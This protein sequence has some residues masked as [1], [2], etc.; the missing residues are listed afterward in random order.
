MLSV[1]G[2]LAGYL[3]LVHTIAVTTLTALT[4]STQ[5]DAPLGFENGNITD[6]QF[7]ASSSLNS[8]YTAN[9][10]RLNVGDGWVAQQSNGTEYLQVDLLTQHSVT[11]YSVQ[12][13][14]NGWFPG[15]MV[16]FYSQDS[17]VWGRYVT[18][19]GTQTLAGPP[20]YRTV[21][22]FDLN[23]A[24]QARYLAFV[25]QRRTYSS[26]AGLRLELYG[27]AAEQQIPVRH[28][29]VSQDIQGSHE[30]LPSLSPYVINTA[31][32][33]RPAAH[34][35]IQPG[36]KVIFNSSHAGFIVLGTMEARGLS[37]LPVVFTA[38]T[39]F[40]NRTNM[41]A[42]IEVVSQG[43][44]SLEFSHIYGAGVGIQ[45]TLG[46]MTI[47]H[48]NI[49]HNDR[50]LDLHVGDT[51]QDRIHISGTIISDNT[52]EGIYASNWP[53]GSS[54]IG[55]EDSDILRNGKSGMAFGKEVVLFA[56]NCRFSDNK[57]HG[58]Y[59]NYYYGGMG[60]SI[61]KCMFE[62]NRYTG[63][64][65]SNARYAR[66]LNITFDETEFKENQQEGLKLYIQNAASDVYIS[67]TNSHF[68]N[69][70][71]HGVQIQGEF[72]ST[73]PEILLRNNTMEG[74]QTTS[75]QLMYIETRSSK[76][77]NILMTENS[78]LTRK[79]I[80]IQ[81]RNDV[82]FNISNN[83][84]TGIKR[85]TG[86]LVE[87]DNTVIF[88]NIF[89]NCSTTSV[90]HTK[91]VRVQIHS[92]VF[93]NPQTLYDVFVDVD[94]STNHRL[95]A[96]HN[97]WGSSDKFFVRSR[98]C[99]FFCD[100]TK[101]MAEVDPYFVS[102]M[103][104][105]MSS[106]LDSDMFTLDDQSMIGGTLDSPIILQ[107][108]QVLY[109]NRSLY[110]PEGIE[111][112]ISK[113]NTLVFPNKQGIFVRGLLT[114][115]GEADAKVELRSDGS[116]SSQRWGGIIFNATG[117]SLRHTTL[118]HAETGMSVSVNVSGE[119]RSSDTIITQCTTAIAGQ[120]WSN[121]SL[122]LERVQINESNKFIV[123]DRLSSHAVSLSIN[124]SEI[125]SS[126][127]IRLQ[128]NANDGRFNVRI[129][130][131]KLYSSSKGFVMRSCK[132]NI[133][134]SA[135]DSVI[136]SGYNSDSFDIDGGVMNITFRRVSVIGNRAASSFRTCIR[137]RP[138]VAPG[139]ID[140]QDSLF[141]IRSA[142]ILDFGGTY[143]QYTTPHDVLLINNTFRTQKQYDGVN[144]YVWSN[145]LPWSLGIHGNTFENCG[146][147]MEGSIF[148]T[149]I[150]GNTFVNGKSPLDINLQTPND[151]S[152]RISTNLFQGGL[153]TLKSERDR[154]RFYVVE[155]TFNSS[156]I[157]LKSPNVTLNEN[158]FHADQ[159]FNIKFEGDGYA[160]REINSTYNYWGT[161]DAKDIAR[162][163]FD[164]SYDTSLPTIKL[165]PFYGFPNLTN[166][167]SPVH[168]FISADGTIGGSIGGTV[169]LA[170]E[171]SPYTVA[172]N[173]MVGKLETLIVEAGVTLQFQKGFGIFVE[174]ALIVHGNKSHPVKAKPV[175]PGEKWSGVR[176]LGNLYRPFP[177]DD[178]SVR[179][180]GGMNENEGRLEVKIN[181]TWGTVC[182]DGFDRADAKVVCRMLG[183]DYT[184]SPDV[185]S[186]SNDGLGPIHLGNLR[187]T[188]TE[189]TLLE[190]ES[191]RFNC[192]HREDVALRCSEK[193]LPTLQ[194]IRN[195]VQIRHFHMN[196]TDI[197]LEINGNIT[198]MENVISSYSSGHGV[199]FNVGMKGMPPVLIN[200]LEAVH[201][202]LSGIIVAF[203]TGDYISSSQI[204]I[205][206]C[207]I[208]SNGE[209]G[210]YI[211]Q[212]VDISLT[213]CRFSRNTKEDIHVESDAFIN[214]L[215]S[216]FSGGT[217]GVF[218][219]NLRR[220]ANNVFKLSFRDSQFHDYVFPSRYHSWGSGRS[221]FD[222]PSSN[223]KDLDI[224]FINNT[225]NRITG[226][227]F[228]IYFYY[229]SSVHTSIRNNTFQNITGGI[230]QLRPRN[231]IPFQLSFVNNTVK[232]TTSL[233]SS[234]SLLEIRD[235]RNAEG[236]VN[237][238]NNL[239]SANKAAQIILLGD[240][241]KL[242]GNITKNIFKDNICSETVNVASYQFKLRNNVFSNPSA[243]CELDAPTFE[244]WYA[245]DAR[246]NFW[247]KQEMDYVGESICGFDIDMEKGFVHYLPYYLSEEFSEV[248]RND[249]LIFSGGEITSQVHLQTSA[250]PYRIRTSIF[251]RSEGIL[252]IDSGVELQ[253]HP[254]RGIY[255]DGVLVAGEGGTAERVILTRAANESWFGVVL[256]Y[257][258]DGVSETVR[259]ANG[260]TANEGR[261]EVFVKGSWS[262]VC[263]ID[264][265]EA[266]LVCRAL[267]YGSEEF[268]NYQHGGGS[269]PVLQDLNCDVMASSLSECQPSYSTSRYCNHN[270]DV[271]V[272]CHQFVAHTGTHTFSYL[273]SVSILDSKSGLV[274]QTPTVRL[275]NCHVNN[276]EKVG[277]T[278]QTDTIDIDLN[279]T[280]V[281]HGRST[282]ILTKV[283]KRFRLRNGTTQHNQGSGII[284][285]GEISR[286][287][288]DNMNI[289]NNTLRGLE[290][291]F[292]GYNNDKM[293]LIKHNNFLDHVWEGSA[294][295]LDKYLQPNSMVSL[296]QNTFS[297]NV[298]SMDVRLSSYYYNYN[299][300]RCLIRGNIFKSTGPVSVYSEYYTSV[301]IEDNTFKNSFGGDKCFFTV[302]IHNTRDSGKTQNISLST[303]S[304]QN[305]TGRCVVFVKSTQY[306][307][308][309]TL[310]YNR[311]F[312]SPASEATVIL[313]SKN[314]SLHYNTLDNPGADY[315]LKILLTGEE[316]IN[317]EQNW[318]GSA[319]AAIA[320][321]R[322]L[323]KRLDQRLLRVDFLPILTDQNFDCSEVKNCSD[324]GECV[325][326]NGCRCD[327]GWA[328][329]D[330]S[331][332]DCSGVGNCNGNGFCIGPNQCD[333]TLGWEGLSCVLATCH[334]VNDC[335]GD[336]RGYCVLPEKCTCF[337]QYSGADC[338][339][340]AQLRWGDNCLPCPQCN[341]GSCNLTN[342]DCACVAENW[343]GEL[344]DTC[345]ET[346]YG[347][348]C[349][350]YTN[351]LNI[352]PSSGRDTGGTDVH[353]WGHN[354]PE[355]ENNIFF[356]RFDSTV[357]SGTR[358]SKEHITCKNP[359]HQAGIVIVEISPDGLQ[360][361]RNQTAFTY[362]EVC[363][364]GACG[365]T[366]T[367]PHGHCL[368]GGC[369]C[370]LPW[371]GEACN[372][373]LKAPVISTVQ[374]KQFAAEGNEYQ[375]QLTLIEGSAP[376]DWYLFGA[377]SGMTIDQ[378]T[379]LIFWERTVARVQPYIINARASNRV[380][381]S[382]VQWSLTVQL[383]YNITIEEVAPSGVL[384]VPKNIQISGMVTY[385]SGTAQSL[386][387]FVDVKVRNKGRI[388]TISIVTS[389]RNRERFEAVYFPKAGDSGQFEVD[390]RHPSDSGFTPQK[391]WS[392]LG[393]TCVPGYVN[394]Q[395]YLD[396]DVVEMRGVTVLKNDGINGINGIT[397]R[398]EGTGGPLTSVVVRAGNRLSSVGSQPLIIFL[399]KDSEV[400]I[401]LI[402]TASRPLRGVIAVVFSTPD[403]TTARV[404][405][406][407]QLNVRKPVLVVSPTSLSD[408]VPRGTQKTFQVNIKNEGE[409]TAKSLRVTMP[410]EPRLT[411]SA[412]ST[413]TRIASVDGLD[414]QPNETAILVLTVTTGA[415]DGLGQISG[416]VA[417][418]SDLSSASISY[419]FYVT[420]QEKLNITVRVEDEYTYFASDKPLVSGAVVTLRNP[421]RGY[422]EQRITTNQTEFVVFGDVHEDKYTLTATA[423]GHGSYSR[424]VIAKPSD[425]S[426]T[427]F[428]QRVAVKYTWTVTRTTFE[429]KYTIT[430][431]STFETQVPMPVVTVEPANINL[432][433]YEEGKRDVINFNITNHGLIRADNARFALPSH[434]TLI[435]TQTIDP[436]GG[437]EANTSVIVPVLVKLKPRVKR[438]LGTS[439]CGLKML[440]DYYC[441]GTKTGGQ[442]ITLTR[443]Y[444]GRPPLPC[445]GGVGGGRGGGGGGY[446]GI[447]GTGGGGSSPSSSVVV[448]NPVTPLTCNCA[449]TLIKTCALGFH[450][451]AGCAVAVTGFS[452]A[453]GFWGF[454][455]AVFDFAT[456]CVLPVACPQCALGLTLWQ[457]VVCI[458]EMNR[459]CKSKRR[460]RATNGEIIQG[461]VN[462]N[463]A[464]RN[465]MIML[466][467]LFGGQEMFGVYDNS[468]TSSFNLALADDSAG[469]SFLS[470]SEV[471][472]IVSPMNSTQSETVEKFL[473]RWNK[474]MTAWEGGTLASLGPKDDVIA[475]N[476]IMSRFE[477]FKT[478]TDN[479]K[480]RGFDSI[481]DDF[482]NAVNA[483][484]ESEKKSS[485]D[486]GVCAKVRVRIVQDLVLTRDAF[487]ARLEI[488]NGEQSALD[489]I[490]VTVNI[491]ATYGDETSTN[492]KFSVGTPTLVGLTGVDG[493]GRLE[494][495]VSGTAEW[496]IIPYSTAAVKED[497]LYDV[498]G[499]LSYTV[500]GSNFSIPLLPDTITVKP[501][502]S[503]TVNYF[504]EKYVQGD[505]PM[506][507][508][509][510]EPVVPFTLAVM[511]SN[512]AYGV[513]RQLKITSAQPEIIE[514]E[515]GLLVAFKIIGAQLDTHPVSPS[516]SIDF[517]DIESFE[518]KTARWLL[519]STL[520]GK[521]Y[522]YTATFENINPLGDPQLSIMEDLGYH[523]LVHLV[524]LESP[525]D[526]RDDF[527]VN[528]IIDEDE[529][530]DA[531]FDSSNGF[532]SIPVSSSNVM[533]FTL[534]RTE[535]VGTRSYAYVDL[536]AMM[537][538]SSFS[539]YTYTR[540]VN[541]LTRDSATDT[542]LQ[543]TRDDGKK[544][545]VGPNAWQTSYYHDKFYLH[546]FD[547]HKNMTET[548]NISYSLVFGPKNMYKPTFTKS[549][550]EI[551]VAFD[552]LPGPIF[553][554][555]ATD[556][557]PNTQ[558]RYS[559]DGSSVF[560]I[561]E[562]TGEVRS[563]EPLTNTLYEL[564]VTVTDDGIPSL[565]SSVKVVVKVGD[566]SSSSLTSTDKSSVTGVSTQRSTSQVSGET[567][568]VTV[569]V[570]VSST[571]VTATSTTTDSVINSTSAVDATSVTTASL[572]TSNE[573]STGTDLNG[574]IVSSSTSVFA[575]PGT[576]VSTSRST[577]NL[578]HVWMLV[579]PGILIYMLQ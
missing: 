90:I 49:H 59:H 414:L 307:F 394:R 422:T 327:A 38:S 556:K 26:Y 482:G 21:V 296:E 371:S 177:T 94:Y 306:Q 363:P 562:L 357:V 362:Y 98:I 548:T 317:A 560:T 397:A 187:C 246:W 516:L 576:T 571:T 452:G 304:F 536:T 550:Y 186:G 13:S 267:G 342:G 310:T 323:D 83:I 502:P 569:P 324:K 444:P 542:L 319:D 93:M 33:I 428:L 539:N 551:F 111:L 236:Q 355:T 110:I 463:T 334:E 402:L 318:W 261:V 427:I 369:V 441:G 360:F 573:T 173:I 530:P 387:A 555:Q 401:D 141:D 410:S 104:I 80:R 203:N 42:G 456:A 526:T 69:N 231:S 420:S 352:I 153:I 274:V 508:E 259:L 201:S 506:T 174:G 247:G 170:P 206:N 430:L 382:E 315:E 517:G 531:V 145:T 55:I 108:N 468:W 411:M 445:G 474:T 433:P 384:P 279:G 25:P 476:V 99:D 354:F 212:Y 572:S 293:L 103:L 489:S 215:G 77:G 390:G 300:K 496:L 331:D 161:T 339:Q 412:Y 381:R 89:T 498:G 391:S 210:V 479:A 30:W 501:N 561:S 116:P 132:S 167:Q 503:L 407:L 409:V 70:S 367:P 164:S 257:K 379:G 320:R 491:R 117:S 275:S 497:T 227:M 22:T 368:Y 260:T 73:R 194:D 239:F 408:S 232:N 559:L 184:I 78:F 277:L 510:V 552:Q 64:I 1:S 96:S 395:A 500:D 361:T 405:I 2:G 76:Y 160:G 312:N 130:S 169:T 470:S 272:R 351:V 554:L 178:T 63:F 484:Q 120:L 297:N 118:I 248:S 107:P 515:K 435:F 375:L 285:S 159:E 48:C 449:G 507:S 209:Y 406:G 156:T 241:R 473:L 255:V 207:D 464:L 220:G 66:K 467:E 347:P 43:N 348:N 364:P 469:G 142:D 222:I 577:N 532:Y 240:I 154:E 81:G 136:E 302:D 9:A 144:V 97:F 262:T 454:A 568:A 393:M 65:I 404:R 336:K 218:K 217:Y 413:T 37:G 28:T 434:P 533:T 483:Y 114:I 188:G 494:T 263:N 426:Y 106:Q 303:N 400:S 131:S 283:T 356:C 176:L 457:A 544:I 238:A 487:T 513:A 74:S 196:D 124:D 423:P 276:T 282:G 373:E 16:L 193:L 253:F 152:T 6:D 478:D 34:V 79:G 448:Y 258:T 11:R 151:G 499:T 14:K 518:T 316:E 204:R 286:T 180:V 57:A 504:Q 19:N 205:S 349:L 12:G 115:Q 520:R 359:Q 398:V 191:S 157:V 17:L 485:S 429:D 230:V 333:C 399:D 56:N 199:T 23:P 425:A 350:P 546:I 455:K 451:I 270:R 450:P 102:E 346:F 477:Q 511:V 288:V 481:F 137:N 419:R 4:E 495:D 223:L 221:M 534:G 119:I 280:V 171:D 337:P 415:T 392:V 233:A 547:Y 488:E 105:D 128:S 305:I 565:S 62:N 332:F 72:S 86:I 224:E 39:T 225:F 146:L 243:T 179:L 443:V 202:H 365:K 213:S 545:L 251:V 380:G 237:I 509:V 182:D 139:V 29:E 228:Y 492:D 459:D 195:D 538:R 330:C 234:Q 416:S 579:V 403:G 101:M 290:T 570:S 10:A 505:D 208:R 197:G 44:L 189:D 60:S 567:S 84:F 45:G 366:D 326:P 181:G 543:V 85:D 158:T 294:L 309:G 385:F 269:G 147:K 67:I 493:T 574:T 512:G 229:E 249:Q 436:I 421:R 465:Y 376:I 92:N 521:F 522:N 372:V 163:V 61:K 166:P 109:V 172:D 121:V 291:Q 377:P 313:N 138:N 20:D 389:P 541:N 432:I 308:N 278:I 162:R 250:S 31:I 88:G 91:N 5:C 537:S 71:R 340:C 341:H 40:T 311:I 374:K 133:T 289:I 185:Y 557:D 343:S 540:L 519:T 466:E 53:E 383:S 566:D 219:L 100:V 216:N 27:C 125:E 461:V 358:L 165:V 460:R 553:E 268:A 314:V 438:N 439:A 301:Y 298:M 226:N 24:V 41:W 284:L 35:K 458:Y 87:A 386:I 271:G 149:S 47:R 245:I 235:E 190:C 36:V 514:N 68:I 523:E 486:D 192:N 453:S 480:Q 328:G 15:T 135:Y 388:T 198:V 7:S 273:K 338:S 82:A 214:I 46:A 18:S 524:R 129:H 529:M 527:L 564:T 549:I 150:D 123:L 325:R 112:T 183:Y 155:N 558:L 127:G 329:E 431:D 295:K 126:Y 462:S 113:N 378:K 254:N 525:N 440:Y 264:R 322:I 287:T 281:E 122:T 475:Y 472:S 418:N 51:V 252:H 446:V 447:S 95:N 168:S 211:Q 75:Y 134:I 292:N 528:D 242:E 54:H 140:I 200:G 490:R 345:S 575:S 424:V 256:P 335:G 175:T 370:V 266:L 321:E 58:I 32:K 437:V 396:T 471:A 563:L 417:L 3:V 442:D 535:T 8:R 578:S 299:D 50:G 244:R 148:N 52:Q 353:I 344:C 143:Y 265:N